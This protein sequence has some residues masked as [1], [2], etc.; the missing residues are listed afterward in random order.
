MIF[1]VQTPLPKAKR[2]SDEEEMKVTFFYFVGYLYCALGHHSAQSLALYSVEFRCSIHTGLPL[3]HRLVLPHVHVV[4]LL[5]VIFRHS[6]LLRGL[7][8][9]AS[10]IG[11][12][13]HRRELAVT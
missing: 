5:F 9:G 3:P 2:S 11:S 8:T 12:A 13:L 6:H 1:S 7:A 10:R 4:C